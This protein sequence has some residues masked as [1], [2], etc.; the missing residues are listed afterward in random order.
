LLFSSINAKNPLPEPAPKKDA[1]GKKP[2]PKKVKPPTFIT[3]D[4]FIEACS[5]D[6]QIRQLFVD[7]I[8]CGGN[9][10][11]TA[12]LIADP[13]TLRVGVSADSGANVNIDAGGLDSFVN[14]TTNTTVVETNDDTSNNKNSKE[15]KLGDLV[16]VKVNS[17]SSDVE[18]KI[19]APT[20]DAKVEA[21]SA[22]I[23]VEAPSVEINA[24]APSV[25]VT[26]DAPAV[27]INAEA[28]S[29]EVNAQ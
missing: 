5:S 14:V 10:A 24:E 12:E 16:S 28:P 13:A 3:K 26:A 4:Q 7:S 19:E 11:E 25:E 23:N 15:F 1:K 17:S 8:F 22:E 27:E 20:L 21:P 6:E 9:E 2:K 29:V 18:G